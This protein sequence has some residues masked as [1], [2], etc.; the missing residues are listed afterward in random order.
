MP[1][2]THR[3][4][5]GNFR[6]TV[7][8]AA[9]GDHLYIVAAT[10]LYRVDAETGAFEAL[11][12][13]WHPHAMVGL[14]GAL[15]VW[16]ASGAL[17]RTSPAEGSWTQVPGIWRDVRAVTATRDR[18]CVATERTLVTLDPDTG[19]TTRVPGSWDAVHLVGLGRHVFSWEQ[20]GALYRAD[21]ATGTTTLLPG[22]WPHTTAAVAARDA[23]YAVDDGVLYRVDPRTGAYAALGTGYR[24]QHLVA[25]GSHL[26]SI[27]DGALYRVSPG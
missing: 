21:L 5:P 27:E 22:H 18:L 24:P 23:L 16:E 4:L 14:G 25:V 7:A 19:V 10:I 12:D 13:R 9:A 6:Q 15:Y 2:A 17:Y 26:Y 3:R 20:D 8:A 1:P 11:T